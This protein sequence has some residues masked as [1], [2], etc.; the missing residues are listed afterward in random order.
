MGQPQL[1]M[2]LQMAN[3]LMQAGRTEEAEKYPPDVD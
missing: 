1:D 3:Q 2:K